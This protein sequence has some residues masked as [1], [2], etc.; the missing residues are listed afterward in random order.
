MPTVF[1]AGSIAISRLHPDVQ[2]RISN[3]VDAKLAILVGDADGADSSIQAC[4]QSLGATDVTIYCSGPSPRNNLGDWPVCNIYPAATPGSRA[5]YTAKDIEMAE[6][7]DYGLMVWDSKS[8]GTLSNVMQ[9]LSEGKK[10][11][12]FVNKS[13]DFVT[14]S[15][16]S[17]LHRLLEFMSEHARGKAEEKIRLSAK[18][19]AL[20]REQFSLSI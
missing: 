14:V 1:I 6:A 19:A 12:V 2:A 3:A 17:S 20:S 10:S 4:L 9:L 11:V 5:F 18:I 8:T 16:I 13:K 15:D 7:A